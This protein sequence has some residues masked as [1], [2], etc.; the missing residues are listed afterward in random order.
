MYLLG[1]REYGTQGAPNTASLAA[2]NSTTTPLAGNSCVFNDITV[3]DIDTPCYAG[4]PSCYARGTDAYGVLSLGGSQSLVPA[5]LT[6]AGYD[7][8]TGL[9][10]V[11]ATNLANA[12]ASYYQ[13][14]WNG[15]LF[16][17]IAAS[18][19][20]NTNSTQYP[21]DSAGGYPSGYINVDGRSDL[22]MVNSTTGS[23][24]M[25]AMVGSSEV[26]S[27]MKSGLA[28][29]YT[30]QAIGDFNGDGVS[31]FAWTNPA[32]NELYIWLNDGYGN[33]SAYDAGTYPAGWK[34]VG[35]ARID[36][37]SQ[38]QLVWRNDSTAQVGWWTFSN[39]TAGATPGA[40]GM[41][42]R[43]ISPLITAATGYKL[44]LGSVSGSEFA[45]FIWTG[46]SNDLYIWT[47]D[48]GSL[49]GRFTPHYITTFPAGWA[50]QGAGDVNGDGTA[51]LLWTNSS[52]H[53]FGWWLMNGTTIADIQS[54]TIA[55]G[56]SI[57]TVGDFNGDG[58]VDV[59]FDNA[60]GNAYLWTSEGNGF[61]SFQLTD[62]TGTAVTIPAGSQVI[63]NRLQGFP[64]A[65]GIYSTVP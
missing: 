13:L 14:G 64:A 38:M 50:L 48:G 17:P 11:N 55:A 22:A 7:Y 35:A 5:Y 47:N 24:T 49:G 36:N 57:A 33:V 46:P 61:Q 28:K 9:G 44:T 59:L 58:L 53:Q 8:A 21:F 6:N 37:Y 26:S 10:S 31:D 4:T 23:L 2:C 29:G 56:Y 39:F 40:L 63:A 30:I 34:I 27:V 15:Y 54:R 42:T 1:T 51:D 19:F 3:G 12:M 20:L 25:M 18:D 43:T 32:T 62:A 52:T 41:V 16:E 45:D 60:A 65:N